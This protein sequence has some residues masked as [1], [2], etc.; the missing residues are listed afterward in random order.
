MGC[1]K[2]VAWIVDP[3]GSAL[4]AMGVPAKF[5][6]PANLIA[7]A[8]K[9]PTPPKTGMVPAAM[10]PPAPVMVPPQI[11]MPTRGA[12]PPAP[13]V[14]AAPVRPTD[15]KGAGGAGADVTKGLLRKAGT[16]RSLLS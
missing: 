7:G 10:P 12:P 5:P 4:T 9:R 1:R 8:P 13:N 3:V 6:S 2:T 15:D 16:G 11:R 14:P